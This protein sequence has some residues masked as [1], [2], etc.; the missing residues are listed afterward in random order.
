MEAPTQIAGTQADVIEEDDKCEDRR[1]C[2]TKWPLHSK[3]GINHRPHP[4]WSSRY[5]KLALVA[6]R[7]QGR[8]RTCT[9]L[10][11]IL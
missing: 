5:S 10:A 7:R 6:T 3:A 2:V 11:G 4:T 9:W 8:M 1:P